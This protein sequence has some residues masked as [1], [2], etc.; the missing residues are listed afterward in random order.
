MAPPRLRVPTRDPVRDGAG[1]LEAAALAA[2]HAE[3][4]VLSAAV[5]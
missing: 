5:S 3:S 1:V 4:L 2:E